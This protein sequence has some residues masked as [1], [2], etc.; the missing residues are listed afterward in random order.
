MDIKRIENLTTFAAF[1]HD[2]TAAGFAVLTT[3]PEEAKRLAELAEK[4]Y[5]AFKASPAEEKQEFL[6]GPIYQQLAIA[7]SLADRIK[8]GETISNQEKLRLIVYGLINIFILEREGLLR[9]DEHNGMLYIYE[10]KAA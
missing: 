10:S 6:S 5:A 8:S 9:S 1:Y 7:K 4:T 3:D 2:D